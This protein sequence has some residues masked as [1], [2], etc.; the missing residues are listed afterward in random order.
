MSL[1]ILFS[2]MDEK[3]FK[4]RVF[5]LRTKSTK[6][7][8]LRQKNIEI[9]QGSRDTL[10]PVFI[11]SHYSGHNSSLIC[12]FSHFVNRHSLP[13]TLVSGSECQVSENKPHLVN[14]LL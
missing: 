5:A 1:L 8:K 12:S 11:Y 2:K 3:D 6:N 14:L 7:T 13:V 9:S 4:R 10:Y